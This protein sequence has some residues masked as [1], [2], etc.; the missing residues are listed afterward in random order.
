M[1]GVLIAI[2]WEN[3]R[4]GLPNFVEYVTPEQICAAFQKVASKF[5]DYRG[6]TVFGDWTLRVEEARI[7]EGQGLQAYNVLRSRR[8]KD[9]SDPAINLEVYDWVRDRSDVET[10]ILGSGD[11]DFQ[12]LIRRAK[13]RGNQVVICA[14]SDTI[15]GGMSTMTP[16]FPLEA[17]LNLTPKREIEPTLP[18]TA[19][20]ETVSTVQTFVRRMDS[21]EQSL[22]YVVLNYL[23]TIVSPAW[24]AGSDAIQRHA[25][26]EELVSDGILE[27][28]DVDN[29]KRPGQTTIAIRLNRSHENVIE[30]LQGTKELPGSGAGQFL[31]SVP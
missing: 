6:G 31:N 7:F 10:F 11:S 8:G 26:L 4:R 3:I 2:D 22:P 16:V 12:E 9:R 13:N 19:D 20:S 30:A 21:I 24:G 23:K 17:E 15:A 14:F 27:E 25:F 29:P 1:A 18:G 28:Y 5:G